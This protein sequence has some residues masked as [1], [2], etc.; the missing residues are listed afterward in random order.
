MN[1]IYMMSAPDGHS[2][3]CMNTPCGIGSI[4]LLHCQNCR[5]YA[6]RRIEWR[7]A[8]VAVREELHSLLAHEDIATEIA[9]RLVTLDA[10]KTDGR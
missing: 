4:G 5:P 8:V 6:L 10:L 1:G 3:S 7:A 9:R 2:P